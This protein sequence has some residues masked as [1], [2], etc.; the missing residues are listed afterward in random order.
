MNNL[1]KVI[2]K[3]IKK[4]NNSKICFEVKCDMKL[5]DDILKILEDRGYVWSNG[6][7]PTEFMPSPSIYSIDLNLNSHDN[8]IITYHDKNLIWE[9]LN[10]VNYVKYD[11]L[12]NVKKKKVTHKIIKEVEDTNVNNILILEPFVVVY[13]TDGDIFVACCDDEDEFNE[14]VGVAICKTKKMI[15]DEK[16]RVEKLKEEL[17]FS[18][19]RIRFCREYLKDV[20]E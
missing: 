14:E 7:L 2:D 6:D 11:E 9:G 12:K 1:K 4:Y 15:K 3:S 20:N 13:F 19:R 5:V 10:Y 8:H 17:K 16:E 18:E